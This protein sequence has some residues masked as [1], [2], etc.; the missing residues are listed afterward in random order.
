MLRIS[1]KLT[2]WYLAASAVIVCLVALTTYDLYDDQRRDAIDSDLKEYANFLITG[3]D[4]DSSDINTVFDELLSR[5]DVPTTI[6]KSHRFVLASTDTVIYQSNTLKNL[7]SLLLEV[8]AVNDTS[9]NSFYFYT[10]SLNDVYYRVYS[11]PFKLKS[12]KIYHLIVITSLDRLFDSL[13]QLR[14]LLF[15]IIPISLGFFGI[16]GYFIA[17]R[18]FSPVRKII[19]A[20][21]NISSFNLDKRVPV[22]KTVDEIAK[23]AK[24]INAM[25]DRLDSTFKSQQRFI[26]DASHD[27]R[28]PLT[29]LSMELELLETN[30][31][32]D[33]ESKETIYKCLKEVQSLGKL[34]ENLLL[35]ARADAHRLILNR[36]PNRLD[37]LVVDALGRLQKIADKKN[38]HFKFNVDNPISVNADKDL[39]ERM[40]INVLEN[41]V[42]FSPEDSNVIVKL[43]SGTNNVDISVNNKGETIPPDMLEM[44]FDRFQRSDKARTSEGF[45]LGLAISKAIADAHSGSISMTSDNQN[46]TTLKIT[47]PV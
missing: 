41:A 22:G 2:I 29:V 46:G 42:K 14:S 6:L 8:D 47:L 37:E 28:T 3:L 20:A 9:M 19:E 36:H 1:I 39:L 4:I 27:I 13:V 32:L 18:A 7:E 21:E 25:I 24:T 16:I 44:I 40:I 10:I 34:A 43:I 11:E 38:V 45:G 33:D 12:D 17:R 31:T 35:L 30:E 23:L 26:A 15:T 5:K